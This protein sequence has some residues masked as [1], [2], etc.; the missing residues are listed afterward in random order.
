MTAPRVSPVPVAGAVAR[1]RRFAAALAAS[2]CVAVSAA[3]AFAGDAVKIQVELPPDV[4][5]LKVGESV[6][7]QVVGIDAG[8]ARVAFGGRTVE[9]SATVGKLEVVKAP[10]QYRFTAPDRLADFATARL[11]AWLKEAPEVSGEATVKVVPLPPFRRITLKGAGSTPTGTT[12][13]IR[14]QGEGADGALT[15]M[16]E[17]HVEPSVDGPGTVAFFRAGWL[18]YEAPA[19]GR[20]TAKVVVKLRRHPE[21]AATHEIL[22]TGDG[23]PPQPVPTPKPG[24]GKDPPP[25]PQPPAPKPPAPQPPADDKDDGG[26]VVWPSGNVKVGTWRTKAAGELEF[27]A[28]AKD[29]P[30]AGGEF[31]SAKEWQKLRVV[32]LR[33]DV[34]KVE[35][36]EFVGERKGA[37]VKR[38]EPSKDGRFRLERNKRDQYVV[39]YEGQ[40]PDGGKPL[41]VALLIA[42]TDGKTHREELTLRRR[43][44]PRKD[45]AR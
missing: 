2:V 7:V 20:G 3:A 4:D 43:V 30:Q 44:E 16:T 12:V 37:D 13:D 5:A 10:Y 29:L 41:V 28:E 26:G 1:I 22:L 15:D 18:R 38:L 17:G 23:A 8:G 42:T 14:V 27:S 21:V 19:K 31:V 39:H 40:T 35:L 45:G 32:V 6:D 34:A 36:E 11:R 33:T 24:D 9:T 25:A